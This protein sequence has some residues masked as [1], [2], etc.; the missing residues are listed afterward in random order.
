M[1]LFTDFFF[2]KWICCMQ[3]FYQWFLLCSTLWFYMIS[4]CTC[5]PCMGCVCRE[6]IFAVYIFWVIFVAVWAVFVESIF[7]QRVYFEL[8]LLLYGLCLQRVYFCREYIL[9]YNMWRLWTLVDLVK[10]V[11][12]IVVITYH[13]YLNSWT[14]W[15]GSNWLHTLTVLSSLFKRDGYT[16]RDNTIC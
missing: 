5:W 13:K 9:S 3:R 12:L 11:F 4:I 7:L 10:F 1:F 2:N 14:L 16:R 8:Y 6:Y 15:V